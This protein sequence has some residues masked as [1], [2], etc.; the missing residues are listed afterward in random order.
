MINEIWTGLKPA[1]VYSYFNVQHR[2]ANIFI[3]FKYAKK[4]YAL[5]P[6]SAYPRT[7]PVS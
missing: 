3:T 4:I 7:V 6:I 2:Y 1:Q 5:N